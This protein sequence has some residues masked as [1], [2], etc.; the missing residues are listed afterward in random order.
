MREPGRGAPGSAVP[1]LA[2]HM[3][4]KWSHRVG[5]Q[6]AAKARPAR[7]MQCSLPGRAAAENSSPQSFI[8]C[9][10]GRRRCSPQGWAARTRSC[11]CS[12][13][14]GQTSSRPRRTLCRFAGIAAPSLLCKPLPLFAPRAL[15]PSS[16][17][18]P[19]TA[20][21]ALLPAPLPEPGAPLRRRLLARRCFAAPCRLQSAVRVPGKAVAPR[22]SVAPPLDRGAPDSGR[23]SCC[24]VPR[25]A[26]GHHGR[27]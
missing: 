1:V 21:S 23:C 24:A 9:S 13:L 5:C 11:T 3:C 26:A 12:T 17:C 16:T 7:Q 19:S 10:L 25:R 22:P 15:S 6:G 8:H 27:D 20:R 18:S 14:C 2:L 4:S